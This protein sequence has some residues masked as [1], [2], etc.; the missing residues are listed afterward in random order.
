MSATAQ[1]PPSASLTP[2]EREVVTL[3]ADGLTVK[4]AAERLMTSPKTVDAQKTTAM[5]KLGI[6]NRAQLTLWAVRNGLVKA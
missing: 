3:L 5:K 2:R 4:K 6:H 1:A